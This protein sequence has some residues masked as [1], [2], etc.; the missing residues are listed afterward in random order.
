MAQW[1]QA[2]AYMALAVITAAGYLDPQREVTGPLAKQ[3]FQYLQES[4]QE[5]QKEQAI[6]LASRLP[7]GGRS[8]SSEMILL[9]N[10]PPR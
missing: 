9:G 7:P 1:L 3:F 10:D 6:N 5:Y 4:Y 2:I 8:D